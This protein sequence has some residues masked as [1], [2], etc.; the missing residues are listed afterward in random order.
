MNGAANSLNVFAA[1]ALFLMA[2][3]VAEPVRLDFFMSPGCES[4]ERIRKAVL[5]QVTGT[6]EL[7]EHDMTSPESVPLL[8]AYQT[9]CGVESSEPLALVID[10]TVY[11]AGARTITTGLVDCVNAALAEH[12]RPG[13]RLPPPPGQDRPI[14]RRVSVPLV[15]FGGLADGV[16][17]CA[18]STLIFFLSLLAA[19]KASRKTRLLVGVSFVLASFCMYFALGFGFLVALRQLPAFPLARRAAAWALAAALIVLAALSFRDAAR[20]SKRGDPGELALQLPDGV[21]R[22]IHGWMGTRWHWGGPV[23]GGAV[24]GFGVTL[25]ESVCTGQGYVPTLAYLLK[26]EIQ[27]TRTLSL[28][29]LYNV[30][31]VLP[32]LI[33]LVLFN[34]GVQIPALIAWSREH[35]A[36]AKILLGLFFLLM[37]ALILL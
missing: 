10:R 18:F 19:N 8:L 9:K 3:A 6:C 36:A 28:L 35:L 24:T 30:C 16:N 2:V 5:P 32:L 25:L 23:L 12:K 15:V 20:F 29:I 21:K 37:A 31:F 1:C 27:P 17:P 33:V 13:W 11:L 22:S 14:L 26:N 34:R 4:C 7:A